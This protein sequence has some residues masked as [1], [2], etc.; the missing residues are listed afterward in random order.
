MKQTLFIVFDTETSC[1]AFPVYDLAWKIVD[2]QGREY[3]RGSYFMPDVI[4]RITPIFRK[5]EEYPEWITRGYV[6]RRF[7]QDVKD[8]FNHQVRQLKKQGHRVILVAYNADF[9]RKALKRTAEL[10]GGHRNSRFFL[11]EPE[12]ID[13]WQYWAESAPL[14]YKT[15][16][17]TDSGQYKSSLEEVF[18]FENNYPEGYE[19]RHT[20]WSDTDDALSVI[21][22][23]FRRKKKMPVIKGDDWMPGGWRALRKRCPGPGKPLSLSTA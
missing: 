10:M 12:W 9:D 8:I 17:L 21:M 23:V 5:H 3:G 20:A 13:L 16:K 14:H 1:Q 15:E 22:Q 11:F 18:R 7:Y 4:D 19:E 6:E 2:R